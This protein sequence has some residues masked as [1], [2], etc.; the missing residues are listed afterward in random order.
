MRA[1][2]ARLDAIPHGPARYPLV[3]ASLLE[4]ETASLD[5]HAP[6]AQLA[7]ATASK[8]VRSGFESQSGHE[9]PIH[10]NPIRANQMKYPRT[11]QMRWAAAVVPPP[12]ASLIVVP[13][14]SCTTAALAMS[15][16]DEVQ[17]SDEVFGGTT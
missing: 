13:P 8:S 10:E 17:L 4:T 2:Q 15:M 1:L 9:N 5:G 11:S 3:G 14:S 12:T 16:F 6:V 7:E